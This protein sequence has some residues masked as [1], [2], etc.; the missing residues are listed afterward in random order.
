MRVLIDTH[1]WIWWVTG[2]GDLPSAQAGFLDDLANSGNPPY[3]AAISLWE[4]QMLARKGRL[5]L[6]LDF[7]SWLLSASDPQVVRLLP[8]DA[9][10]FFR[11]FSILSATKA[12]R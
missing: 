4:A 10:P 8:L 12:G 7:A 6:K 5:K 3:L 1:I 11:P 9:S 2:Q